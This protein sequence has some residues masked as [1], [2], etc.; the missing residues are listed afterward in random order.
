VP[1]PV[2]R[3]ARAPVTDADLLRLFHRT[4]R[5]W[6]EHLGEATQLD[7]GVAI[8]APDLPNVWEANRMLE[9]AV[10]PGTTP[11]DAIAEVEKHF[12]S[13]GSQCW[14]WQMNP[15]APAEHTAL[16][17]KQLTAVG[18][19]AAT[20][21]VMALAA[22]PR[23]QTRAVPGSLTL[24]PARA[25]FRQARE[26]AEESAARWNEPQVAEAHMRHL[27]DPHCDALLALR[28]GRAVGR[29]T[30]LAVGDIGR[31]EQVYVTDSFRRQG[32]G[33]LLLDRA[34]EICAR[35]L[36][37]HIMLCVAGDNVAAR[38]LYDRSGFRFVGKMIT[39]QRTMR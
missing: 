7:T 23:Q 29:I 19:V 12:T 27:D 15:S 31:I 20:D 38:A 35:S 5:F 39:Y 18:Y 11:G 6:A 36:F 30:V 24:L 9:A 14:Q 8:T 32:I 4:E 25:A 17:A 33:A 28:D 26:L 10:P 1:L 34:I 2:L 3:N 21:E 16:L 37:R 13:I 22:P